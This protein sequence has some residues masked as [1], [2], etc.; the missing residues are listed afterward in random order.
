VVFAGA[1]GGGTL[2]ALYGQARCCAYVPILEGYGL[3]VVEAMMQGTPVVSS[4]VPSSGGASL[5]VDPTDAGSIAD[6]LVTAACDDA[7]RA[8]LVEGGRVRAASLRWVD[9]A[10]AHVACWERVAA[11]AR[12]TR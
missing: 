2:A 12:A 1:V 11:Q 7:A 9:A 5:V 8:R 10:R 3:P 4:P 6:G